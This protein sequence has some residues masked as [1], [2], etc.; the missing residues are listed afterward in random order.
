MVLRAQIHHSIPCFHSFHSFCHY[1]KASCWS[2]N[3]AGSGVSHQKDDQKTRTQL[4]RVKRAFF[5]SRK[6]GLLAG[7]ADPPAGVFLGTPKEGS[8]RLVG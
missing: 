8:N 2:P 5:N 1:G 3:N 4:C 7:F 6:L